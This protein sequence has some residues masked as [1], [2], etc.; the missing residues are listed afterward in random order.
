M[1]IECLSHYQLNWS[2]NSI[3]PNRVIV[4]CKLVLRPLFSARLSQHPCP[5]ASLL[6]PVKG[7]LHRKDPHCPEALLHN[8]KHKGLCTEGN[9]IK[10]ELGTSNKD[11]GHTV[12]REGGCCA[13]QSQ[14][15]NRFAQRLSGE[16]PVTQRSS[17]APAKNYLGGLKCIFPLPPPN[18]VGPSRPSSLGR[19][20]PNPPHPTVFYYGS[21]IRAHRTGIC[22]EV[23]CRM[24]KCLSF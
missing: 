3:C 11:L 24:L 22:E 2:F 7:P 4:L 1:Y 14:D 23:V 15:L 21:P 6:G 17:V 12:G 19:L 10:K 5:G 8:E 9:I 18:P 13:P 16:K 20:L